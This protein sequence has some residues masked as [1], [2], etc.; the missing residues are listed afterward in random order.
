MPATYSKPVKIPR[1]ADTGTIV[2]PPELKKDAGWLFEEIPPSSF[3]NW[4]E[5]LNGSWWKWVDERL[6]DG[7]SANEL[8]FK[9]PNDGSTAIKL[10]STGG[11]EIPIGLVVGFSAAPAADQIRVGDADL[12]LD[13]NAGT[14]RLAFDAA[15][16]DYL[17]FTRNAVAA[18]RSLEFAIDNIPRAVLTSIGGGRFTV[19]DVDLQ[20]SLNS[21]T[22]RL[23]FDAARGDHLQFT[24]NATDTLRVLNFVINAVDELRLT[25][26]GLA[27]QNGLFVGSAAGA[28]T[29]NDIYAQ[30]GI[31]CG[32]A[33]DPGSGGGVFTTGLVVGFDAIPVADEIRVGDANFKLTFSPLRLQWDTNDY[34]QFDRGS[35]E[36][37][38]VVNSIAE[39]QI[40]PSLTTSDN[41]I[42]IGNA[43]VADARNPTATEIQTLNRNTLIGSYARISSGG[44]IVS[45]YNIASASK[46]GALFTINHAVSAPAL[47]VNS[48]I[49]GWAIEAG[50]G[51]MATQQSSGTVTWSAVTR[52][53]STGADRTSA[54]FSYIRMHGQFD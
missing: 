51:V 37:L 29:D 32:G 4:K 31:N 8:I 12:Q 11:V 3:E 14:P 22:P 53:A 26:A 47:S 24:R 18:S 10:H 38:F 17:Q 54:A 19:G 25:S 49:V 42:Y 5:N 1:W 2:E 23:V 27:V 41:P 20:L 48:P 15:R 50:T 7:A 44:T 45:G 46:T 36:L 28:L 6:A 34:I 40:T 16:N 35:S 43:A 52:L 21:G 33:V 39:L 30:G 13:F 9:N